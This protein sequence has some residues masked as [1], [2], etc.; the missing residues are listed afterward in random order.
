MHTKYTTSNLKSRSHFRETYQLKNAV[1]CHLSPAQLQH[2]EIVVREIST[3]ICTKL[4][5]KPVRTNIRR[6]KKKPN[7]FGS[8]L[9]RRL[10]LIVSG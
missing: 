10:F 6:K 5:V 2:V 9:G 3:K 8:Y 1:I 4:N 7:D